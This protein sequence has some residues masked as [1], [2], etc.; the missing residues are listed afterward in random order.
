MSTPVTSRLLSLNLRDAR[1]SPFS[2]SPKIASWRITLELRCRSSN[3][4]IRPTIE[5]HE[6]HVKRKSDT[7]GNPRENKK[8]R[9]K[10]TLEVRSTLLATAP[11]TRLA[12]AMQQSPTKSW[13]LKSPEVLSSFWALV[14]KIQL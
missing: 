2:S 11:R 6:Q 9:E 13:T 4:C 3:D 10:N 5:R 14:S 1:R 8:D 7:T 12:R